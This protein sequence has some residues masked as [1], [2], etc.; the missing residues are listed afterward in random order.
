MKPLDAKSNSY[1]GDNVDSNEKS[2]NLKLM[3]LKEFEN[4]RAFFLKD[5]LLIGQKK[6][7]LLA[8]LQTRFHRLMLLVI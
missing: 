7:L 8:K 2:L 3:V 6:F 1:A 5:T 4:A